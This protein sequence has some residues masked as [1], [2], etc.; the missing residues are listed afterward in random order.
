MSRRHIHRPPKKNKYR[1]FFDRHVLQRALYLTSY[2]FERIRWYLYGGTPSYYRTLAL[3]HRKD[4]RVGFTKQAYHIMPK[5]P[6]IK[7]YTPEYDVVYDTVSLKDKDE[8]ETIEFPNSPDNTET[9]HFAELK[10]KDNPYFYVNVTSLV[11]TMYEQW[12][13]L[14]MHKIYPLIVA[15]YHITFADYGDLELKVIDKDYNTITYSNPYDT[16]QPLERKHD[17]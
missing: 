3:K 9:I 5:W 13:G 1:K 14:P 7:V 10:H 15:A 8:W 16:L 6:F 4:N 17:E 11:N 12:S 2:L